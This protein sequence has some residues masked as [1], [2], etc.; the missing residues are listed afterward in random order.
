VE[1]GLALLGV[2]RLEDLDE[3]LLRCRA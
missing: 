3:T 2:P 1:R